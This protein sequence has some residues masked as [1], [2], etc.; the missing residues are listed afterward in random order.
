MAID[1]KSRGIEDEKAAKAP[2]PPATKS[3]TKI[4]K[5]VSYGNGWLAVEMDDGFQ[6]KRDGGTIAWRNNNPG[7]VKY[8]EFAIQNGAVGKGG[9][10]MAVFP[11]LGHGRRAQKNLL[12]TPIRGYDEKSLLSAM[13]L[14]APDSDG[15]D[16]VAYAH[17]V[18]KSAKV[19]YLKV[20]KTFTEEE[21]ERML[22]A[23]G[24]MEGF[25]PGVVGRIKQ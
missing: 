3:P 1:P 6:Y 17:Y 9:E 11:T 21:R 7:N 16:P 10:G 18:A 12:F 15:N 20:L 24:R 23:M 19:S 25:R 8:G 14:Y 2:S 5:V 13:K 4:T 22:D